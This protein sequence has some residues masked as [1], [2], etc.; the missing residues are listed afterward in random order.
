MTQHCLYRHRQS[1]QHDI[2]V[3]CTPPF[4]ACARQGSAHPQGDPWKRRSAVAVAVGGGAARGELAAALPELPVVAV[5]V[6][7]EEVVVVQVELA[8]Q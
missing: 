4:D 8:G 2:S 1:V 5:V 6:V 3:A 7:V